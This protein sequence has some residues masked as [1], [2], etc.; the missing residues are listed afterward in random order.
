VTEQRP[1]RQ[2]SAIV[3]ISSVVSSHDWPHAYRA[4]AYACGGRHDAARASLDDFTRM[5][6]GATL[7]WVARAEPYSD[8]RLLD[9][10][11]DGLRKAGLPE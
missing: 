4:S 7:S 6:P 11:L 1:Q 5:K 8:Q 9:Q 10:L 2:L 3:A